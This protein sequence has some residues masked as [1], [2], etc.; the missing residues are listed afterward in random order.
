MTFAPA[1]SDHSVTSANFNLVLSE[2]VP[3]TLLDEIKSDHSAW[4]QHLPAMKELKGFLIHINDD[5]P[6]TV[7]HVGLEFAFLRPD[8][9]AAWAF[10]ILENT[11][12]VECGRYT[13]W[14]SVFA[15]V[16]QY[17]APFFDRWQAGWPEGRLKQV[18][19]VMRD[20][21]LW[22]GERNK[23]DLSQLL[24]PSDFTAR[25]IFGVGPVWHCNTAWFDTL[26]DGDMLNTLNISSVHSDELCQ[27]RDAAAHVQ[28]SH[29]LDFRRHEGLPIS[30][31][32]RANFDEQFANVCKGMH[33]RNK[34]LLSQILV[35]DMARK[36]GL[37]K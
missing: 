26:D 12:M 16:F 9:R 18:Q 33:A 34:E 32:S 3:R 10:R 25:R 14:E 37:E 11:I 27:A 22:L 20:S 19:V 28:I 29:A 24:G 6:T 35:E 21:Y 7:E 4:T 31:D 30:I 36:I 13:R 5:G 17:M 1:N 8:G 15:Q 23:Y 2:A